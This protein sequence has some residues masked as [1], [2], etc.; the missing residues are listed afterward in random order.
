MKP[1]HT[2]QSLTIR[3][4]DFNIVLSWPAAK[5]SYGDFEEP[6]GPRNDNFRCGAKKIVPFPWQNW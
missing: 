1:T 6:H 2:V 4:G 5:S 3:H